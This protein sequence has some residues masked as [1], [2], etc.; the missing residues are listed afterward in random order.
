MAMRSFEDLL[1]HELEDL[2]DAE[3]QLTQALPKMAQA[4]TSTQVRKAFEQHLKETE[5]QIKRLEQVFEAMGHKAARKPCKAMQGLVAEANEVLQE[6]MEGTLRDA[7]LIAAA[8]RVEHYEMAGYGTAR[9][10]AHLMGNQ[11]AAQFLQ[12]TLEEEEL[13]DKKLSQIA[14]KINE[15]AMGS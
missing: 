8:Q 14:T 10:Y 6:D 15:H 11:D 1:V 13:T 4:A 12:Q 7:A 3:H 9:T 2:Y 5:Q